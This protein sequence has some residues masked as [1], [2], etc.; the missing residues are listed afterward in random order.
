M[1]VPVDA[2]VA[3]LGVLPQKLVRQRQRSGIVLQVRK[4]FR[5]AFRIFRPSQL[6]IDEHQ[7]VVRAEIFRIDRENP[8]VALNGPIVVALNLAKFAEL[9]E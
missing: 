2:F 9:L 4:D 3:H 1:N 5:L 8:A 7:V 6:S